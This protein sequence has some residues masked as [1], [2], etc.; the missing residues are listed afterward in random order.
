MSFFSF[1]CQ[2]MTVYMLSKFEL[3]VKASDDD[4]KQ[5]ASPV[6]RFPAC[7]QPKWNIAGGR[8]DTKTFSNPGLS[9]TITWPC[10]INK[11]TCFCTTKDRMCCGNKNCVGFAQ[12]EQRFSSL[13]MLKLKHIKMH[14]FNIYINRLYWNKLRIFFLLYVYGQRAPVI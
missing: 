11:H 9:P 7:H 12:L 3:Y 1:V 13:V 14:T 4:A 6:K 10:I 2:S 8:N 5:H